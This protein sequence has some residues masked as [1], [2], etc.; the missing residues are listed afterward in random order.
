MREREKKEGKKKIERKQG[1][2]E[3]RKKEKSLFHKRELR[4]KVNWGQERKTFI[5]L[6][7]IK[8]FSNEVNKL[9]L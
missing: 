9:T 3:N 7:T 8:I 4:E 2:E 6:G 1:K 5:M